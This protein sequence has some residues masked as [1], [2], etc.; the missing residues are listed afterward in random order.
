MQRVENIMEEGRRITNGKE[1]DYVLTRV[2][3]CT[4]LRLLDISRKNRLKFLRNF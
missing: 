2:S 1:R 4:T 3:N